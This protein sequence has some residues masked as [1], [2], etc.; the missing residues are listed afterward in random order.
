MLQELCK[1][2][3]SSEEHV[4]GLREEVKQL[5]DKLRVARLETTS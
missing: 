4:G 3:V 2:L 5:E 1:D